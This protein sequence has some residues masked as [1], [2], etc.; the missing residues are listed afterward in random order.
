MHMLPDASIYCM[1]IYIGNMTID[2]RAIKGSRAPS[3]PKVIATARADGFVLVH[4]RM[5]RDGALL[6][7]DGGGLR[8]RVDGCDGCDIMNGT[9][10]LTVHVL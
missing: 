5:R 8:G 7:A 9:P 4:I 2:R 10:L 6:G 1:C 3:S